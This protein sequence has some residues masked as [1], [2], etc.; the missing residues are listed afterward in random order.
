M[1]LSLSLGLVAA[2][3]WGIHDLLVRIFVRADQLFSTLVT[4]LLYGTLM[5]LPISLWAMQS[6][7]PSSSALN[8]TALSGVLYAIAG[9][10]LYKA[11]VIGP[12]RTVAPIIG[13][14]PLFSIIY[15]SFGGDAL[16]ASQIIAILV[17]IIAAGYVSA[18][19]EKTTTSNQQK[20]AV[21]WA[22]LAA[23]AFASSF[24]SGH[25]ASEIGNELSLLAPNRF[26]SLLT[27]IVVALALKVPFKLAKTQRGWWLLMAALD[28]T[29]Q[30]AVIS[31]GRLEHPSL[32]AVGASLF[33]LI[34]VILAAVFLKERLTATLWIA[35]LLVFVAIGYLGV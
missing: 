27:I 5:Q 35:V 2:L 7:L 12:V 8:Y 34:T 30:S 21:G 31:A 26:F 19:G 16:S 13:A 11:F 29:A 23:F 28:T 17:V 18:S 14:Y 25:S 1:L 32:A 9:I 22:L 3:C 6:A 20:A 15:A 33:G 24:S 4:V 10:A